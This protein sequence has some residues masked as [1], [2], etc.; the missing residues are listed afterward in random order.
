MNLTANQARERIE[1]VLKAA[2]IRI[3]AFSTADGALD[4]EAE[5]PDGAKFSGD[6]M[7]I[8]A[9]GIAHQRTK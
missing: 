2:G 7:S 1:G 4:T 6:L 3:D 8:Y 5:F 9:D